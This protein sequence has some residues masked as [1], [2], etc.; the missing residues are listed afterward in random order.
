M[1]QPYIESKIIMNKTQETTFF[2]GRQKWRGIILIDS[3]FFSVLH[4]LFFLFVVVCLF[5]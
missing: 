3:F 4:C 2:S 5:S 1:C